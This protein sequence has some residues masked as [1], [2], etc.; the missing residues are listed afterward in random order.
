MPGFV[1]QDST[2]APQGCSTVPGWQKQRWYRALCCS[3][4]LLAL[5]VLPVKA[6][7]E[8]I[9]PRYASF[10]ND[11]LIEGGR[12]ERTTDEWRLSLDVKFAND[13]LAD[14]G[15]IAE[16]LDLPL[17]SSDTQASLRVFLLRQRVNPGGCPDIFTPVTRRLTVVTSPSSTVRRL[18]LINTNNEFSTQESG[19]RIHTLDVAS[20]PQGTDPRTGPRI[21]AN[22]LTQENEFPTLNQVS[23]S[24]VRQDARKDRYTLQFDVLASSRCHLAGG[25]I[26]QIIESPKGDPRNGTMHDWLF[27]STRR[28]RPCVEEGPGSIWKRYQISSEVTSEYSRQLVIVN[29]LRNGGE[30]QV[31][32]FTILNIR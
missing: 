23:L 14:T 11:P 16:S 19:L 10:V 4:P 2:G 7:R 20:A 9:E 18:V 13:C 6:Q 25:I 26:V 5:S 31:R 17:R 15:V 29:R 21:R 30:T 1:C 8:T 32:P 22:A 3:L 24:S 12:L 27:V 28:K